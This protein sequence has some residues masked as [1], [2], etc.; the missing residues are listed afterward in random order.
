LGHFQKTQGQKNSTSKKN[1][2]PFFTEMN[3]SGFFEALSK[4]SMQIYLCIVHHWEQMIKID[5]CA[6]RKFFITKMNGVYTQPSQK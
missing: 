6:E 1:S 5:N 4:N 3:E 2:R